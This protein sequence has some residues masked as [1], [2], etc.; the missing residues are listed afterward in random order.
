MNNKP[1][2]KVG[3]QVIYF[4]DHLG[5]DSNN[6]LAYCPALVT[7][8][9]GDTANLL[10]FRDQQTTKLVMSSV[11]RAP[12]LAAAIYTGMYWMTREEAEAYGINLS[13]SMQ[14]LNDLL[15]GEPQQPGET[16]GSTES[17]SLPS[18]NV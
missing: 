15:K 16:T 1:N 13:D 18:G 6:T 10:V 4:V 3:D 8:K 12:S 9:F 17:E 11:H 14:F 2:P 7:A 5:R